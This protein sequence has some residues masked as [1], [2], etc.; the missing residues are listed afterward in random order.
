MNQEEHKSTPKASE[1]DKTSGRQTPSGQPKK[2]LGAIGLICAIT[3]V[4]LYAVVNI[5]VF[6]GIFS[7][8]LSVLTPIILGFALAYALNPILKFFEFKVFKKIKNKNLLRTLSL[9]MTYLAAFAVLTAFLLLVIPQLVDSVMNFIQNFDKHLTNTTA[10]INS[11]LSNVMDKRTE[12]VNE[13]AI[14]S[15]V[16]GLISK[17]GDLFGTVMEYVVQYGMGL[18][19]SIKNIVLAIF[20]SIYALISKERLKAQVL[21]IT[22]ALCTHKGKR[23]FYRYV[24][25]CHRT[26]GGFFLGKIIDSFIIGVI[27]LV[28]LLIFRMPYALLVST[29]VCITNIIPIFGPIIGA[30]PSFFIIFIVDP[31]KALIFLILI[32]L[33]QQLDG[34]V[35]GPKILGNTTGISTLGV[36][37]SIIIMGDFFGVIGMIIGVPIF[38]FV[39]ALGKEFVDTKLRKKSLSADTADYYDSDSLVD[40]HEEHE[41]VSARIFK[42]IGNTFCKMFRIGDYRKTKARKHEQ[43]DS[44]QEAEAEKEKET[45]DKP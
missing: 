14:L 5:S 22:T 7:K 16:R 35:I 39:V 23:R 20:I 37:V 25:L 21:K 19:I 24:R 38:A 10:T 43:T 44:E 42:N 13:E 9:L 32:L 18:I 28:T 17:S 30:I 33:I 29:I 12:V 6:A 4:I 41:S 40:P 1:S 45:A 15:A 26:F 34:N 31:T 8:I 11:F 27:T 2:S 36:I 3:F